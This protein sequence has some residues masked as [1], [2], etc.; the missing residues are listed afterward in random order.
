METARLSEQQAAQGVGTDYLARLLGLSNLRLIL[1]DLGTPLPE[2][3]DLP[4]FVD[5]LTAWKALNANVERAHDEGHRLFNAAIPTGN[6]DLLVASMF[7]GKTVLDGLRRLE[8]GGR[9]LR[10]DLRLTVAVH[11]GRPHLTID[12]E[13]ALD[14]ARAVYLEAMAMVIHCALAWG[15]ERPP[16]PER[17]RGP[18]IIT[19]AEGSFLEIVGPRVWRSGRGVTIVYAPESGSAPL[20]P[21][22]FG[23]WHDGAFAQYRRL[24]E[25]APARTPSEAAVAARVRACLLDGRAD[26]TEVASALAMSVATLRRRLDEEGV[27]FRDIVAEMKRNAATVL[28]L[29]DQTCHD[30]AAELGY[31][32]ARCFRRACRS[33]FGGS[34]STVRRRLKDAPMSEKVRI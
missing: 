13:G 6:F 2:A 25:A 22:G 11:G 10:P 3:G 34:P 26:Q 33:W 27:G 29:S 14:G 19:A 17:V 28:L 1:R 24:V 7:H 20:A 4:S 9:I 32:D 18:E 30:M 23:G 15:S 21:P 12:F 8:E 31:S 16:E 5:H